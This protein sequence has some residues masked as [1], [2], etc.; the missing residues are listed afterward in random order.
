MR[1]RSAS[2]LHGTGIEF[3]CLFVEQNASYIGTAISIRGICPGVFIG[4]VS[5]IFFRRS[6]HSPSANRSTVATL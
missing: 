6:L 3:R 5:T 2:K 4:I 1:W